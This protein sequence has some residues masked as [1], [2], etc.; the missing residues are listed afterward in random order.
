MDKMIKKKTASEI[1]TFTAE[2]L[3]RKIEQEIKLKIIYDILDDVM[4]YDSR[5]DA[6][7]IILDVSDYIK[8]ITN[9]EVNEQFKKDICNEIYETVKDYTK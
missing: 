9:S 3:Y 2:T 8:H 4:K 1:L 7:C 6:S 5:F